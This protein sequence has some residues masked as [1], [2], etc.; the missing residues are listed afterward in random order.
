VEA[1]Q[2]YLNGLVRDIHE[3]NFTIPIDVSVKIGA[4][5]KEKTITELEDSTLRDPAVGTRNFQ[6]IGAVR[7]QYIL[8]W[9]FQAEGITPQT[10]E[11]GEF[12]TIYS[13]E[14]GV[15]VQKA[16][17][18]QMDSVSAALAR[19][20]NESN[21]SYLVRGM[22]VTCLGSSGTDQVFSINEGK[23]HVNGYEIELAH[24]LR[25]RFDN[26]I[27]TQSVE[28]DPYVF[29]PNS[30]GVMT[31]QLNYTPL[32]TVT[33]VDITAQKTVNLTHG[34]YN[35]ALDPIPSTS[36]LEI[37]LIKQGGTIYTKSTDYKLTAGQVDWSLSGAEPAPGSTYEITYRD[38]AKFLT[39][40]GFT[41]DTKSPRLFNSF[42]KLRAHNH[43]SA[44]KLSFHL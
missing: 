14:H 43:L 37:M 21:G 44:L 31:V 42:T 10:S 28:S 36:V 40:P 30:L 5:F 12:Y 26:E 16:L 9:G 34:S 29:E 11:L 8:N 22:N 18:P 25:V 23:A 1:G 3:G 13:V 19:Y 6:E 39:K 32:A 2:V 24:S 7:N 4:Y 35:G 27:D 15:L 20:D 33:S 17:A 38:L 41:I